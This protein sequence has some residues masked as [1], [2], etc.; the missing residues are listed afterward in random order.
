MDLRRVFEDEQ[1]SLA[2]AGAAE[3]ERAQKD[4]IERQR[5]EQQRLRDETG[6]I[7]DLYNILKTEGGS[8]LSKAGLSIFKSE[9]DYLL[10]WVP[11]SVTLKP[12][13][14]HLTVSRADAIKYDLFLLTEGR[15]PYICFVKSA[16]EWFA[17]DVIVNQ[18]FRIVTYRPSF[19]TKVKFSANVQEREFD[20]I[21]Q[22]ARQAAT[23][24]IRRVVRGT[25]RFTNSNSIFG[26][27]PKEVR[28]T[29]NFAW[30]WIL[31]LA[32]AGLVLFWLIAK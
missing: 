23:E 12:S 24:I 3:Q 16:T 4:A 1:A 14:D 5:T 29:G 21:G 31:S 10:D 7:G 8:I 25:L 15:F 30:I 26:W 11:T 22:D 18:G 9:P 19:K 13:G 28:R 6:L 17:I 20:N 32:C 27:K 2:A